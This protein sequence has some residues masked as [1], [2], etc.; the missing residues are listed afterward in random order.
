[1]P[2]GRLNACIQA[3][4]ALLEKL[5]TASPGQPMDGALE[6]EILA[7]EARVYSVRGEPV[8]ALPIAEAALALAPE[9]ISYMEQVM[10][11]LFS[12]GGPV[13]ESFG[14]RQAAP[15]I[16]VTHKLR[17]GQL[18]RKIIL[19]RPLPV[20]RFAILP[21]SAEDLGSYAKHVNAMDKAFQALRPGLWSEGEWANKGG[22]ILYQQFWNLFEDAQKR[23]KDRPALLGRACYHAGSGIAYAKTIDEAIRRTRHILPLEVRCEADGDMLFS[24]RGI[25]QAYY[26]FSEVDEGPD[27]KALQ[28]MKELLSHEHAFVRREASRFLLGVYSRIKPGPQVM[29]GTAAV[30]IQAGKEAQKPNPEPLMG[31]SYHV[32]PATSEEIEIGFIADLID[33]S[34]ENGLARSNCTGWLEGVLKLADFLERRNEPD[35][36]LEYLE[37][38]SVA[39]EK[40]ESR[41]VEHSPRHNCGIPGGPPGADSTARRPGSAQVGPGSVGRQLPSCTKQRVCPF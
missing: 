28:Y 18:A 5:L 2:S 3:A 27:S 12:S 17:I 21:R 6:A 35:R 40:T 24:M 36:A 19:R 1:M 13:W 30:Y 22:E 8:R 7:A 37:K 20:Q 34:L 29:Q 10:G 14:Q 15:D 25:A 23:Y 4:G 41:Q 32:D 11:I 26:A 38:M 31:R 33:Y 39:F 16:V 9:N